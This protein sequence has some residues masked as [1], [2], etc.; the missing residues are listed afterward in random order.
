VDEGK[1]IGI[2]DGPDDRIVR[3]LAAVI[4]ATTWEIT[5][6]MERWLFKEFV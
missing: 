5:A 6:T 3:T 2:D 1:A 4:M